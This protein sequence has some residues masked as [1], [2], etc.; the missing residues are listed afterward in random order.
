MRNVLL[1]LLGLAIG[2]AATFL[3]R[4]SILPD[5]GT[6]EARI[7][8]LEKQLRET[9]LR[10]AKIDP[11]QARPREESGGLRAGARAMLDDLKAGRPVDLNHIYHALKPLMRD[12]SPIFDRMRRREERRTFERITGE[13]SRKYNLT[14]PQQE[15]LK[16]W[17]K[18]RSERNAERFKAVALADGTRLED[19]VRET[20]DVRP[21]DGLDEFMATQLQG[22]A[23]DSFQR[24][25]LTQRAERVQNEADWKVERLHSTVGLDEEQ[26][27]Q[28]FAIM[29]RSSRDFDSQMQ[30]E[31]VTADAAKASR[32]DRDAAIMAVLRPDQQ[33][34]YEQWRAERRAVAEQEFAEIGVRMPEGWDA[35]GSD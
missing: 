25:R 4:G 35:L 9:E 13:M 30:I 14:A 26:K 33:A 15:A 31:G 7:L 27:D 5:T 11:S 21:D 29:A 32:E 12:I 19:L 20:K 18:Q 1:L 24:D 10:L 22:S 2:A 8:E 23:L 16:E 6:P 17:L 34:T 3:I 28:V